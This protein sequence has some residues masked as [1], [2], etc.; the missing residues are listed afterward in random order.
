VTL[1]EAGGAGHTAGEA[2]RAFAGDAPTGGGD[3]LGHDVVDV[4]LSPR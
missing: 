3:P 2:F 4:H 1:G